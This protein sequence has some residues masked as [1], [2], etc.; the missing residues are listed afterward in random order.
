MD[1]FK[2]CPNCKEARGIVIY[3]EFFYFVSCDKCLMSGPNALGP[4]NAIE[5]WNKL[6]RESE[7]SDCWLSIDI[8][9]KDK[10]ILLV[11]TGWSKL[12]VRE[13]RYDEEKQGWKITGETV[14]CNKEDIVGWMSMPE[15]RQ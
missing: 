6:P 1:A 3:Q 11:F 15:V 2:L 10:Y 12:F 7:K 5:K 8:A 13:C 14:V 4:D 9:P